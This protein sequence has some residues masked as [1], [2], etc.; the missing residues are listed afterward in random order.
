MVL[1]SRRRQYFN[2]DTFKRLEPKVDPPLWVAEHVPTAMCVTQRWVWCIRTLR[3]SV[4][5]DL[6]TPWSISAGEVGPGSTVV[7][8]VTNG[9]WVWDVVG[10]PAPGCKGYVARWAD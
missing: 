7:L 4:A 3:Q 10:D 9:R 5:E 6:G 1:W 8:A 2:K